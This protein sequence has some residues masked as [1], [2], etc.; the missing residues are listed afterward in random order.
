MT[1]MG[2]RLLG[3]MLTLAIAMAAAGTAQAQ[4][5][6]ISTGTNGSGVVIANGAM[7]PYWLIS[8]AGG[9][10]N[11]ALAL[12][13]ADQCCGMES[14]NATRAKWINNVTNP[15]AVFPSGTPDGWNNDPYTVVRRTFDLSGYDPSTLAISG[16][17]RAADGVVGAYLNGNLLFTSRLFVD[18][19][20]R[21]A[22]WGADNPFLVALGSTSFNTGINTLD[23]QLETLNTVYDGLYL[24][25][26]VTGQLST[27]PEPASMV[28]VATGLLA[29]AG[30]AARRRRA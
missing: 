9:A 30:A 1:R 10:F 5:I 23:F 4:S 13:P 11:P 7:D 18:G 27:V 25:A 2:T 8:V 21:T 3:R 24:D 20:Q 29:I 15:Q 6:N 12:Y 28:L 16:V 19:E 17:W 14:V 22:N 26:T